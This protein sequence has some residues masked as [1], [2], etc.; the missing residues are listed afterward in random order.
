[1]VI[2][3]DKWLGDEDLVRFLERHFTY[4]TPHYYIEYADSTNAPK[5]IYGRNDDQ[6]TDSQI[7]YSTDFDPNNEMIKFLVI[8]AM[9]TIEECSDFPHIRATQLICER[10]HLTVQHPG[11]DI[12][13]H[14][15]GGEITAVYTAATPGGGEFVFDTE[16]GTRR[17]DFEKNQLYVFDGSQKHRAEAPVA[18]R[19]R[20]LLVMKFGTTS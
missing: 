7:F 3:Y 10:A 15:D 8:K 4:K 19:P 9:E 6:E 18:K 5:T 17:I 1:M 13:W 2:T 12:E 20:V 14:Q 16:S 11:Q